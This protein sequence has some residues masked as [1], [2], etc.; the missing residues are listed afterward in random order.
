MSENK[1]TPT[2]GPWVVVPHPRGFHDATTVFCGFDNME[3]FDRDKHAWIEIHGVYQATIADFVAQAPETK[4][5]RDELLAALQGIGAL[6]NGYCFCF[7]VNRVAD[8]PEHEHT[9]ECQA[10]RAAIRRAQGGGDE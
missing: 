2:P 6:P 9:G 8:R 4:A 1:H 10:A 3:D 7:A 5:Q